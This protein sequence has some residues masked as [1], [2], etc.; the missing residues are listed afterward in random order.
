MARFAIFIL[1][2]RIYILPVL[3][4]P[5]ML[6][7]TPA[8]MA[9][10]LFNSP[11]YASKVSEDAHYD[12]QEV[13][14][15]EFGVVTDRSGLVQDWGIHPMVLI[16]NLPGMQ[17]AWRIK[18][19]HNNPVFVREELSL[20]EP[21]ST[22]KIRQQ[23]GLSTELSKGG[24][25]CLLESFQIA[26]DGWIGHAWTASNGDPCGTYQIKIWLNGKEARTY[27][28]NLSEQMETMPEVRDW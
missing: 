24:D 14:S 3:L 9:S 17:Y 10:G 1:K 15:S 19:K 21:P 12:D 13:D 7:S 5:L 4:Y 27:R 23:D 6:F 22:W 25:K 20:P 2:S 18:L 8:A 11:A 26:D 16:P 28:F